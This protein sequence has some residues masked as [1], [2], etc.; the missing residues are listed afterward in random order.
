MAPL[1]YRIVEH[2]VYGMPFSIN[3]TAASRSGC[4]RRDIDLLLRLIPYAYPHTASYVRPFVELR[5][6]W[7]VEHKSALGSCSEFAIFDAL[8]PTKNQDPEEPSVRWE[9]YE[10]PSELP[11]ELRERVANVRDLM[12]SAQ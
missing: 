4:T 1:A 6:A 12:L 8:T 5:R 10:V 3:P 9:D 7:Y 11:T 2:G